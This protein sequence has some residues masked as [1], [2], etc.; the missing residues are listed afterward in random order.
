[1]WAEETPALINKAQKRGR[2]RQSSLGDRR[3][4]PSEKSEDLISFTSSD[5]GSQFGAKEW[6]GGDSL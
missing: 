5:S 2:G 6:L 3:E 1:M 4:V